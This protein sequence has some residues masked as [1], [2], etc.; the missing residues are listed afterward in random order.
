[1]KNQ[2][3]IENWLRKLTGYVENGSSDIV[4]IFQDD[5]TKDWFAKTRYGKV[6][7]L[8]SSLGELIR[9]IDAIP[10]DY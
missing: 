2:Q 1:M 9:K 10:D 5:A 6:E 7:I 8:A 4:T 3:I